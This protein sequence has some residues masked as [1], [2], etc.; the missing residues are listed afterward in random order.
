MRLMPGCDTCSERAASV[1]EPASMT[2]R[3]TSICRR[4]M[5]LPGASAMFDNAM[6]WARHMLVF[7]APAPRS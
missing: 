1:T 5:T 3:K 7:A 2:A 6:L 4:F